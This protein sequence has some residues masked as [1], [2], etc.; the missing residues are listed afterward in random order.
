MFAQTL[1]DAIDRV[2]TATHGKAAVL[3]MTTCPSVERWDAMQELAEAARS[4]AAKKGAALAD[5]YAL[6]HEEG[7]TDKE[8]LYCKDKTHLGLRRE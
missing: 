1:Q 2:R 7:K 3:L 4:S 8:H 6:F 5:I